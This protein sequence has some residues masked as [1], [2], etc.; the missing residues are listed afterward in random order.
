MVQYM[1]IK[2]REYVITINCISYTKHP[3]V[4]NKIRAKRLAWTG[5]VQGKEPNIGKYF[6]V[7]PRERDLVNEDARKLGGN[8]DKRFRTG[9]VGDPM[10]N[11]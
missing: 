1:K 5:H 11:K 7:E 2:I 6:Q 10:F 4:A 8:G 3:D 9:L